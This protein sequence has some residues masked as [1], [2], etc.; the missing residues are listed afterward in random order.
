M[1]TNNNNYSTIG[2]ESEWSGM[3]KISPGAQLKDLVNTLI[4]IFFSIFIDFSYFTFVWVFFQ[5]VQYGCINGHI[6]TK[7]SI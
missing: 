4:S 1:I 3:F 5:T 2:F 7:C 6:E